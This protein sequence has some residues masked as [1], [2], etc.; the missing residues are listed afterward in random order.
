[1]TTHR[2]YEE[3]LHRRLLELLGPGYTARLNGAYPETELVITSP[4]HPDREV[5]YGVWSEDYGPDEG[6]EDANDAAVLIY[7]NVTEYEQRRARR[8]T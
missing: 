8:Q 5:T 7:T 3:A 1:M 4:M 6:Y 2:A